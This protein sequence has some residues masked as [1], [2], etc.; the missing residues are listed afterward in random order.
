MVVSSSSSGD[1]HPVVKLLDFGIS[2]WLHGRRSASGASGATVAYASPEQRRGDA[3]T[4][5]TDVFALGILMCNLLSGVEVGALNSGKSRMSARFGEFDSDHREEIAVRRSTTPH[6]LARL[7]RGPLDAIVEKA[8]ASAPEDRYVSVVAMAEDVARY[9]GN[10]E[11]SVYPLGRTQQALLWT[12]RHAWL[13]GLTA[14]MSAILL[15]GGGLTL[16][17]HHRVALQ[18]RATRARLLELAHLTD[19]LSGALYRST[20][21]LKGSE[22]A[23]LSLLRAASTARDAVAN[24]NDHDPVLSLELARQYEAAAELEL[25]QDNKDARDQAAREIHMASALLTFVP[26]SAAH[27]EIAEKINYLQTRVLTSF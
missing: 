27:S 10:L 15:T 8:T 5:A 12:Q 16:Y 22:Q 18:E 11:T 26:D 14:L 21:P 9:L 19:D 1:S 17:R 6:A 13:A 4:V 3:L 24:E 7:L 20:E 23:R 25:A 2:R